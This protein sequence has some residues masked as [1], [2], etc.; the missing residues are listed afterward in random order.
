MRDYEYNEN[1]NEG[2]DV[3]KDLSERHFG[4]MCNIVN[5]WKPER[6]DSMAEYVGRYYFS[7]VLEV[8]RSLSII[9]PH[10]RF[11]RDDD[12]KDRL[13][14][15]L[16]AA[17]VREEED[18]LIKNAINMKIMYPDLYYQSHNLS[19]IE[20]Y[21][22]QTA[23][24]LRDKQE[25]I[26]FYDIY[27]KMQDV[28][29]LCPENIFPIMSLR[30][31]FG[32]KGWPTIIEQYLETVRRM[33]PQK[34][35]KITDV[36]TAINILNFPERVSLEQQTWDELKEYMDSFVTDEKKNYAGLAKYITKLLLISAKNIEITDSKL[37][38]ETE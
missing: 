25:Y 21:C 28:K 2:F 7:D 10:I 14:R 9:N 27:T 17:R 5:L 18:S 31:I 32:K 3:E 22:L 34:H 35:D 19:Q 6:S 13:C 30:D 36:L 38:I 15:E 1:K 24:E 33:Y 23:E 26:D 37:I 11:G 4:N 16:H 29:L 8:R 20:C 12:I